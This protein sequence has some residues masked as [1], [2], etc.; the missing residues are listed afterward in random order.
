MFTLF[1]NKNPCKYYTIPLIGTVLYNLDDVSNYNENQ[2]KI[3]TVAGDNTCHHSSHFD[4]FV[5]IDC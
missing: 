1:I 5:Y 4:Q 3:M 2:M